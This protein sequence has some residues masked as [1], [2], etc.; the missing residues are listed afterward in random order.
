MITPSQEPNA[1]F[2]GIAAIVG[3]DH[4]D[5]ANG[6][7][8]APANA[9]EASDV[10]RIAD[11]EGLSVCVQGSGSKLDW[12]GVGSADLR[13]LTHRMSSVREHVWQDM[14]CTVEAGC[15]WQTLQTTLAEHGQHVALDPLWPER[16]TVGGVVAA[17]DSGAL[18]L[19]YGG[20]RD[21]VI[22][23]TL[24]LADG[25]IARSGGKVVKNVAGYDLP[26][27]LCGSFGTLGLITEVT[28]RLHSI[29]RHTA[30]ISVGASTA[31][32][33]GKLL[34][35]LLDSTIS[36]Q[37]MQLRGTA[38]GFTLD[39]RLAALPEVLLTQQDSLI[40]IAESQGLSAQVST[41]AVWKA[42]ERLFAA[43]A[44][45]FKATMLPTR[46]AQ[47]TQAVLDLGGVSVAQATGVLFGTLPAEVPARSLANLRAQLEAEGGSLTMIQI[48]AETDFD[49]W[50]TRPD[51]LPLMRAIK[52]Q[53]DPRGILNPGRFL[54][55]I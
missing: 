5:A 15:T 44:A 48:P 11:R 46:I 33:L 32:P 52:H 53:F 10:L 17:N 6:F 35:R 14:T 40:G 16:A 7:S 18:R 8:C 50:G 19:R 29:A 9:L 1:V 47:S 30:T 20:L 13:L 39:I 28:F 36:I 24:V 55:G 42:R 45:V 4:T 51:T 37:S 54:G 26:K 31:T 12:P 22:G 2:T 41:D 27:L 43:S 38:S 23:M 25:T 49:R 3:A 34:L 21:L